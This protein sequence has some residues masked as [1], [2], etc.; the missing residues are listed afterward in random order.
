MTDELKILLVEDDFNDVK[1]IE[2]ELHKS[3]LKFSLRNTD[4]R[5]EFINELEDF[6]PDIILSDFNLPGF[7]GLEALEI[8][9]EKSSSTPFILITGNLDEETAVKC[10]KLGAWDYILKDKLTRLVPAISSALKLKDEI[11]EKNNAIENLK[12]SEADYQD[13]Y[14]NAPDMFL[15]INPYTGIIT[16]C[17]Q[18]LLKK[19]GYTRSEFVGHKVYEFYT[20]DIKKY[21]TEVL[22]PLFE[23]TGKMKGT[24]L[25]VIKKDGGIIDISHTSSAVY[26]EEG[27][28]IHSR[29]IW[30]DVTE[31]KIMEN[32]LRK[33]EER[34]RMM[35]ETMQDIV[36]ILSLD[37]TI[38]YMNPSATKKL[39]NNNILNKDYSTLYDLDQIRK[40]C[41]NLSIHLKETCHKEIKDY[42]NS[43]YL[44]SYSPIKNADGT[45]SI[46][47]IY[48]DITNLRRIENERINLLNILEAT[49]NEIYIIDHETKQFTYTNETAEINTGY[50][51][52]ELLKM[53]LF[54]LLFNFSNEDLTEILYFFK[55]KENKKIVFESK[56]QRFDKSVYPIE[57]H[58]QLIEQQ[59]KTIIL[60]VIIDITERQK[61]EELITK[62]SKGIE[63][64]PVSVVIT[65]L[66]GNI[67][68][69]NPKF[70]E[71]SG[72]SFDEV[73]G[74][75]QRILKSGHTD[76]NMY[77]KLWETILKGEVWHGEFLNKKKN[78]ELYWED[79]KIGPIKDKYNNITH[80]IGIKQDITS[81]KKIEE[82][83][84]E[85]KRLLSIRVDERTA[86]L[87]RLNAELEK[88]VRMKDEFLASMSHELRTPLNAILGLSE[89]LQDEI[90][91]PLNFNQIK[92]LKTIEDSGRHLLSLINDIL[93]VA[94][95][96]AGKIELEFSEFSV[97]GLCQACMTFI[98]Q[99]ALKKNISYDLKIDTSLKT[100]VADERRLKQIIINLL[101]NAVKFTPEN[102]EIGLVVSDNS[103]SESIN[104]M[105][106]DNGIGI[107][108]E[109]IQK[110]FKP[111]VQIDS[112]LSREYAGTGLGLNLV[113][114]LAEMHF[115][116]VSVESIE[117]RG[118]KFTVSIPKKVYSKFDDLDN[119]GNFQIFANTEQQN[120]V[121]KVLIIE[122]LSTEFEYLQVFK[123]RNDLE[124]QIIRDYS[125]IVE[126]IEQFN[127]D[128][129]IIDKEIKDIKYWDKF[130]KIKNNPA[131]SRIPIIILSEIEIN[132][133]ALNIPN[134]DLI[135]KPLSTEKLENLIRK[136]LYEFKDQSSKKPEKKGS[137]LIV[138]DNENNLLMLHFFFKNR[139]YNLFL[140]RNGKEAVML[141][142]EKI[143][144]IILMDIQMPEMDGISATKAIRGNSDV[145]I[146]NIPI[147]ALTALAM[148]GDEKR[149]LDAGMNEYIKKPIGLKQLA[150]KIEDMLKKR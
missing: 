72:Y 17:N 74:L 75:N 147:I 46:M 138:E 114:N 12:K 78:N 107:K 105:V 100:I 31:R 94:K 47:C 41:K 58:L 36:I 40:N 8:S 110:L 88:A 35:L 34:Y 124:Y 125:G 20:D 122:D 22:L 44:A 150:L 59:G 6:N 131:I 56:I 92:S 144:D 80:F 11:K 102:G 27:Q 7:H 2:F 79:A 115:G 50:P 103:S 43:F 126:S 24:E 143:P 69:T 30:R 148:P 141:A 1:L 45:D 61:K 39:I 140:A 84:K 51:K 93:D 85:E 54:D 76:D 142:E 55:G 4:N 119:S 66:D 118:S 101:S 70:T 98:K 13:L 77:K 23:K 68:F 149:C 89:V 64:S 134:I 19:L 38:S 99:T 21:S 139:N 83:L 117:G 106:W 91:G 127:P 104:F 28:I 129:I 16:N 130:E 81:R 112:S 87:S 116:S 145:N 136:Y 137:I 14:D 10:I 67:E 109:N 49:Q 42:D 132:I 146:A 97:N 135:A 48:K 121:G 37:N 60:A 33:S 32:A 65:D 3:E 63:Q 90:Y 25:R 9:K 82:E 133:E 73:K 128:I 52:A 108:Q 26:N 123:S 113:K 53:S 111:F 15:S 120:I 86:D 57:V 18:T 29:S 5:K 71:S 95:I 96:E 62:L